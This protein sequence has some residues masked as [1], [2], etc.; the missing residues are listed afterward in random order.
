MAQSDPGGFSGEI[1]RELYGAQS[2]LNKAMQRQI[3]W[4]LTMPPPPPPTRV[5]RLKTRWYWWKRDAR[6]KVALRLAPW[7]DEY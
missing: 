5:Q 1:I 2:D 3:H 7:L 6:Q 4:K